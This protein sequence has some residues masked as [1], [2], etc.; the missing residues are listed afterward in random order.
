[1][2][3]DFY[4][5]GSLPPMPKINL[6]SPGNITSKRIDSFPPIKTPKLQELNKEKITYP[7]LK[8]IRYTKPILIIPPPKKIIKSINKLKLVKS[9]KVS[10]C[11]YFDHQKRYKYIAFILIKSVILCSVIYYILASIIKD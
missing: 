11:K 2:S 8:T 5:S 6:L 3:I 10:K 7:D 1:M 9:V 4:K